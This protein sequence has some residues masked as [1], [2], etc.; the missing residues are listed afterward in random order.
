MGEDGGRGSSGDDGSGGS[1]GGG[2]GVGGG[3]ES[4]G[5]DGDGGG[6]GDG[7]GAGTGDGGSC[8]A[9]AY[10]QSTS[11]SQMARSERTATSPHASC[12]VDVLRPH[13]G[14]LSQSICELLQ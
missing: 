6:S 8:V 9:E 4:E 12:I 5:G 3:G 14:E 2:G 13:G 11:P 1:D 10:A 7:G